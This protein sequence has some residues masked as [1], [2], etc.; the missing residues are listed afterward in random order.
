MK[1]KTLI[2]T[3]LVCLLA[4]SAFAQNEKVTL[5][6]NNAPISTALYDLFSNYQKNYFIPSNLPYTGVT[7]SVTDMP[8]DKVLE[9]I[10][11]QAGCSFE[12]KDGTYT[13]KVD[14]PYNRTGI[15]NG[16]GTNPG[17]LGIPNPGGL[18]TPNPGGIVAPNLGGQAGAGVNPGINPGMGNPA[19]GRGT[20]G[21]SGTQGTLKPRSF[22]DPIMK[23][24]I[25]Y[26]SPYQILSLMD[27]DDYTD[28]VW[29]NSGNSGS[30]NNNN[31]NNSNN[32][33]NNSN[34]S[35]RSSRSSN[36]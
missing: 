19:M 9:M 27:G 32:N 12:Y 30:S 8:F 28:V 26:N 34:S 6:L 2:L 16:I 7:L 10:L 20:N 1:I 21:M 13:V 35:S 23:I 24:R 36:R 15:N 14:N 33:N 5:K 4:L 31:S 29:N 25:N 3:V 22:E 11:S 18:G 17:G